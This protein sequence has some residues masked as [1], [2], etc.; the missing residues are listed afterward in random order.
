MQVS[1][2]TSS[3]IFLIL[4]NVA[5]FQTGPRTDTMPLECLEFDPTSTPDKCLFLALMEYGDSFAFNKIS[6]DAA[7]QITF[8]A[9]HGQR[10]PVEAVTGLFERLKSAEENERVKRE[11]DYWVSQ[12][13]QAWNDWRMEMTEPSGAAFLKPHQFYPMSTSDKCLFLALMEYGDSFAPEEISEDTAAHITFMAYHGGKRTVQ[14]T[15][16]LFQMLKGTAEHE[17]VQGEKD[18]WF[19]LAQEAWINWHG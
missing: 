1:Y 18:H 4:L 13:R 11:K 14:A 16:G 8:L 3:T 6:E 12:A 10:Y 7:A 9:Y 17:K 15:A 5:Q 19:N 2:L